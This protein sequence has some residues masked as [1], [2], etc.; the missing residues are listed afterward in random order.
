MPV[1]DRRAEGSYDVAK[2]GL[3][4]DDHVDVPLDHDGP[5]LLADC[6]RPIVEPVE[7]APLVE[8]GALGPVQ[9]FG[10]DI[11]GQRAGPE[12]HDTALGVPYRKHQSPMEAV[13]D[14]P[15]FGLVEQ[16]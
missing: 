10:L 5:S 15:V 2:A 4:G 8:N 1:A 14:R 7:H 3:V 9:V 11:A 13:S 12:A 16:S 6:L